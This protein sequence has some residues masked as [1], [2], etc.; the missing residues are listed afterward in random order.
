MARELVNPNAGTPTTEERIDQSIGKTQA[1]LAKYREALKLI[2]EKKKTYGQLDSVSQG[3]YDEID[4]LS[5]KSHT[6]QLTDLALTRVN[7]TIKAAKELMND[8]QYIAKIEQFIAAGDN[9]SHGDAVVELRQIRQGLSRY[10]K[11]LELNEK[12][13]RAIIKASQGIIYALQYRKIQGSRIEKH[14]LIEYSIPSNFFVKNNNGFDKTSY[15]D[16]DKIESI[17]LDFFFEEDF[18]EK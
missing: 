17:D 2:L 4:K 7:D 3:I 13:T 14:D 1:S 15:F 12:R 8:D 10:N 16:H 9:P 6:G 18:N 5:K 11:E